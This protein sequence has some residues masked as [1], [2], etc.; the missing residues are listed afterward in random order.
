M[1]GGP[2]D[3]AAHDPLPLGTTPRSQRG[4]RGREEERRGENGVWVAAWRVCQVLGICESD[5]L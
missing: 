5:R 2:R 3:M 1:V 4:T